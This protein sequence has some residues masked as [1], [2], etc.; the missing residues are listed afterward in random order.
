MRPNTDFSNQLP[1]DYG[2][3][4]LDS[5][6]QGSKEGATFTISCNAVPAIFRNASYVRL[7]N[8]RV[9]LPGIRPKSNVEAIRLWLSTANIC[10]NRDK[11]DTVYSFS[12]KPITVLFEYSIIDRTV[13]IDTSFGGDNNDFVQPTPFMQWTVTIDDPDLWDLSWVEDVQFLWTGTAVFHKTGGE[14]AVEDGWENGT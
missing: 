3:S 11:T 13:L 8:L 6:K 14:E 7:T 12:M 9:F 4:F 5:L 2:P 1:L 10:S